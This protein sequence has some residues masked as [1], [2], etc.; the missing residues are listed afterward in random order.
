MKNIFYLFFFILFIAGCN[1]APQP[2]IQLKDFSSDISV[3]KLGQR[4]IDLPQGL[5]PLEPSSE[6]AQE[7]F[8]AV[9]GGR[10]EGYE[11]IYPIKTID[12]KQKHMFFYRWPD[13]GCFQESAEKL[14]NEIKVILNQDKSITKISLIGH[15]YGG[16]LVSHVLKHWK[17]TIPMEAHVVA[18]PLLGTSMLNS[19]C[20]YEPINKISNNTALFEWRTQHQLDNAYKNLSDTYKG[21]RLGHNWSISWVADEVF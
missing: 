12:T 20:G 19:V 16:I 8:I 14:E 15:S 10:S 3:K 7:I 21:N 11:W 2:P 4:L 18:S 1:K 17:I 9:H 5:N 6:E 13:N